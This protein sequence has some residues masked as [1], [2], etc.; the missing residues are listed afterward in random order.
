[1]SPTLLVFLHL[2]QVHLKAVICTFFHEH[3]FCNSRIG[4][5]KDVVYLR[6]LQNEDECI[7]ST[8]VEDI[9]FD[10]IYKLLII[11]R[12]NMCRPACASSD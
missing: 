7:T 6:L 9:C 10:T 1:M 5:V 12:T 4:K 11:M 3:S 2:P 8:Q